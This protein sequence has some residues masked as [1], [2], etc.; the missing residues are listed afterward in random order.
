MIHDF[1]ELKFICPV[2]KSP[3]RFSR[4]CEIPVKPDNCDG[5]LI[6]EDEE[7]IYP[8]VDQVPQLIRT[9]NLQ[10]VSDPLK[11]EKWIK[12][13]VVEMEIYDRISSGKMGSNLQVL[14]SKFNELKLYSPTFP[15]PLRVWI[16]SSTSA[17]TQFKAYE[18]LRPLGNKVFLQLGGVVP[19]LLRLL[20][21]VLK[22][23]IC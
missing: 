12:D 10:G 21:L 9:C 13:I 19:T 23:R 22:R 15:Y 7:I 4:D 6:S 17:D 1:N 14:V 20:S 18:H 16:D 8:V 5:Y 11:G 3:L 2:T